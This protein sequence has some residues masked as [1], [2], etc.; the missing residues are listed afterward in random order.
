MPKGQGQ[1]KN[2]PKQGEGG[3]AQCVCPECGA[4]LPHTVDTPCISVECPECGVAMRG[5][6]RPEEEEKEFTITS[7][8]MSL[9][10]IVGEPVVV[11]KPYKK[12]SDAPANVRELGGT[13]LTLSQINWI[14]NMAD[15]L[16]DNPDIE[17]PWAVA[18][19]RFKQVFKK[20]GGKWVKKKKKNS[21]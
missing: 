8:G 19:T 20:E 16:E 2:G 21:S 13:K 6:V 12:I 11:T 9:K 5:D 15:G 3:P 7:R 10:E 14:A 17:S 4:T 18:I 1:G